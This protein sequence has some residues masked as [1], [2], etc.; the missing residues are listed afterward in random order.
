MS[1]LERVVR[2]RLSFSNHEDEEG[3]ALVEYS[4][5]IALVVIACILVMTQLGDIV[6]N[7][8]WGLTSTL[9]F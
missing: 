4:L 6:E 5:I 2:H 3:Q 1:I 9:P 8:L 7:G